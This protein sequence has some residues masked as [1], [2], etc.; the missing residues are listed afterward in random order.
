MHVQCEVEVTIR[1]DWLNTT[2]FLHLPYAFQGCT[3]LFKYSRIALAFGL[4]GPHHLCWQQTAPRDARGSQSAPT[5]AWSLIGRWITHYSPSA[6][7]LYFF[8]LKFIKRLLPQT[9]QLQPFSIQDCWPWR[10]RSPWTR[11]MAR[12]LP[13]QGPPFALVLLYS[14]LVRRSR[15]CL[16][17]SKECGNLN[18]PFKTRW[19]KTKTESREYLKIN[20][21]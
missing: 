13:S 17:T 20:N 18:N 2:M 16:L 10:L 15:R 8:P 1:L 4:D 19:N 11:S 21:F 3:N 6:S 14:G 9:S 5:Q 12:L 7:L